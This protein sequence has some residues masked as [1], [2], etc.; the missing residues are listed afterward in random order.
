[1]T[2]AE[3]DAFLT[4]VRGRV[5]PG[6]LWVLTGSLP[7]G[8]PVE[9]YAELIDIVQG[10]GATAVLDTSGPALR[11][12]CAKRPFLV[13]PNAEEAQ[14]LTG[15]AVDAGAGGAAAVRSF[16]AAGAQR[17]ALS[18]GPDGLLLGDGQQVVYARPPRVPVKTA[19]GAGDALVAGFVWAQ[20]QGMDLL[21]SARW[22]VTVGTTYAQRDELP[23][24]PWPE[25]HEM[26]RRVEVKLLPT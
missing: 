8:L 20:T 5:Q 7:P 25:L 21:E 3:H 15:Q 23:L 12:G 9:F 22:G 1:M 2:P 26:S 24:E 18:L 6:D 17:V 13:K 14:E 11:A 10:A 4:K 19:V 16:L